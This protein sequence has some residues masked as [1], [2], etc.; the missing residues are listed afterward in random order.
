MELDG[1]NV[2]ANQ[3]ASLTVLSCERNGR[4]MSRQQGLQLYN[5]LTEDKP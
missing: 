2:Q 3:L 5:N 1:K 4:W